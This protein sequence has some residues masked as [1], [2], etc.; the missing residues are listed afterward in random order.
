MCVLNQAKG[1]THCL[2]VPSIGEVIVHEAE[3][4]GITH[5][6][7]SVRKAL[8]YDGR[9]VADFR[10]HSSSI[11][12]KRSNIPSPVFLGFDSTKVCKCR[13]FGKKKRVSLAET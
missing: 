11:I 7:K 6:F 10:S 13:F 5:D 9:N 8:W 2:L 1:K 3:F 12:F 4:V